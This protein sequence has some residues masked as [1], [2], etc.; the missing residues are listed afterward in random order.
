MEVLRRIFAKPFAVTQFWASDRY[1]ATAMQA[2][3]T[4]GHLFKYCPDHVR[5]H[6]PDK[7]ADWFLQVCDG[8]EGP[9]AGDFL[10]RFLPTRHNVALI[11]DACINASVFLGATLENGPI[12]GDYREDTTLFPGAALVPYH[13]SGEMML[14]NDEYRRDLWEVFVEDWGLALPEPDRFGVDPVTITHRPGLPCAAAMVRAVLPVIEAACGDLERGRQSTLRD[15]GRLFDIVEYRRDD[16]Q[17]LTQ[18]YDI[19]D[20]HGR[21]DLDWTY[22]DFRTPVQ[23]T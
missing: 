22:F 5:K 8:E 21:D 7:D 10:P 9:F 19:T 12:K 16:G 3:N 15:G 4:T 6:Q 2:G 11:N 23:G 13:G 14:A 17:V 20:V 18:R 1:M